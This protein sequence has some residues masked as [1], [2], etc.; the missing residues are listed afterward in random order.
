[1]RR[2]KTLLIP[3]ALIVVLIYTI[4]QVLIPYMS[5][6]GVWTPYAVVFIVT[7]LALYAYKKFILKRNESIG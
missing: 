7:T 3:A 5:F 1:M 4:P 6:L 2:V